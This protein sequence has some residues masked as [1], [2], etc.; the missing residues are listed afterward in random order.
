MTFLSPSALWLLP[1]ITVP[2]IIHFINRFRVKN[3]K[4]SSI[5]FLQKLQSNSIHKLKIQQILLLILRILFISALVFMLAQPVTRGLVPGWLVG[6]Q[7]TSL[8]LLIDNSA[9]MSAFDNGKTLLDISKNE[10]LALLSQ[11]RKETNIV[12]SQTC[13]LKVLY[14]GQNDDTVIRNTIKSIE[15]NNGHDN[16]WGS[17]GQLI[18]TENMISDFKEFVVFSDFMYP[19]D[20]SVNN[21]L[22]DFQNWK[23][24]FVS[25]GRVNNNLSI[26]NVDAIDRIKS[27]NQ[28]MKLDT[29]IIN[30]GYQKNTNI[31][32]E[33]LFND[34]RVG[35]VISEFDPGIRK[36][37]LFQAYPSETGILKSVITLPDDDYILDNSWFQ[38]IPIMKKIRIGV[39][40]SSNEELSLIEM[41]ISSI[42][43]DN[44]FLE[45][46]T[47]LQPVIQ[48]LFIEDNDIVIMH[49]IQNMSDES[50]NDLKNFLTKGGGVIWF[51]GESGKEN[52]DA[53][54]F[55]KLKFPVPKQLFESGEGVFQT[56][57]S[58]DD[59]DLLKDLQ[60]STLQ[61]ELPEIFKYIDLDLS[62]KHKVHWALNNQNPL[63]LEF[64]EG[65]GNIFYFSTLLDLSWNDL[66]IR[67]MIVPL[68]Y[69]LII[70]TGT[71]EV[72]TAPVL[73]NEPKTIAIKESNLMKKWEVLSPS[74]NKELIVPNYDKELIRITNTGELGIYD[75][76][77][78]G[79]Q[80]AAFSTRLHYKEY[81]K[82]II[83]NTDV[84]YF[85]PN[86][87]IIWMKINSKFSKI[88]SETRYGR[89]LWKIFLIFALIFLLIETIISAP[90]AENLRS[91]KD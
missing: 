25:S 7:D 31:P 33:L 52:F 65:V 51:Q 12:I 71:D 32:I 88:F 83:E 30:T 46:V 67:G 6:E 2:L 13:P 24:Y 74:G 42:D 86:D 68:L 20:S 77:S 48:R 14:R 37:F 22:N 18:S 69:R 73:I 34:R 36:S 21:I 1:I 64:S 16:L 9:S 66:P 4:F 63:L 57:I 47:S 60:K 82:P 38:T 43:P 62:T 39:I 19:P 26:N 72:N 91:P 8:M 87:Q 58:N 49:N 55:S 5:I 85:I 59:Y 17:I 53:T 70:L 90:K 89:P 3:I 78:D 80:Y 23:F 40:G 81:P 44:S 79:E 75:V 84:D 45:T 50:V 29:D 35:Q 27:L 76:L 61:K 54:L 41:I 15:N 56:D 10:S 11:F 28:I